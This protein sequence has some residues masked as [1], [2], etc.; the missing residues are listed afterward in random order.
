MFG[1]WDMENGEKLWEGRGR[2]LTRLTHLLF[3]SP[4]VLVYS[5]LRRT[6]GVSVA[7]DIL[8]KLVGNWKRGTDLV[9]TSYYNITE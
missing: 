6:M 2:H 3:S 8:K 1:E 4:L 7:S 5:S 9:A